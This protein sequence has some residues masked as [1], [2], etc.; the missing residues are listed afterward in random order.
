MKFRFIPL[1]TVFCCAQLSCRA[2]EKP[3]EHN[4][5]KDLPSREIIAKLPADGGDEFNR[6][7][8]ETSPYLRQHARNPVDWYPWGPEAFARAKKENKPIFLS[9]GYSSC[10]WCHVMEHESFEV[11]EVADVLN[12]KFICIKVDREERPDV[13]QIYMNATQLLTGR[14]GWP[15]SVFMDADQRPFFCGTYFRKPDFIGIL[16]NIDAV[17]KKD[18]ARIDTTADQIA[19]RLQQMAYQQL[20]AASTPPTRDAITASIQSLQSTF[21]SRRGGFGGAPKFPPHQ[22]LALLLYAYTQTKDAAVLQM[23]NV[24]LMEMAKG[25]IHDHVGGGFHRYSTDADWFLPHFEKMLYDNA[26]LSRVYAEAYKVTGNEWYE[27]VARGINDW[28]LRDM[29]DPAG[30]FW[31]AYDADSEGEE[32]KYYLWGRKEL[33]EILGE[34]AAKAL[35]EAYNAP[36]GG[37][38]HEEATGESKPVSILH[39]KQPWSALTNREALDT[40]LKQLRAVRNKRVWPGLDDKVLTAWNGLMIGGLAYGGKHLKEPRYIAAAEKAADF[41]L[42][43]MRKPDGRLYTTYRDGQAKL[44]AYLDDYAFLADGLIDLYEATGEKRWLNE[45]DK[46]LQV[47]MQDFYDETYGGFYFTA[48][49]HE[50][51]LT[52]NK[53]PFDA[54]IPSG[55]GIATK[56]LIRLAK[57]LDKPA[58]AVTGR[59]TIDTFAGMIAQSPRGTMS[60][61]QAMA[62]YYDYGFAEEKAPAPAVATGSEPDATKAETP[63]KAEAFLSSL[64]VAPGGE[65]QVALR[66]SLDPHWHVNA[67]PASS[68]DLIPTI[69]AID[70]GENLAGTKVAYPAGVDF[71]SAPDVIQV[72]EGSVLLRTT[73]KA[74]ASAREGAREIALTVHYQSCDDKGVC[75]LPAKLVLKIPVSIAKDAV[76]GKRHPGIFK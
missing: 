56:V 76:P 19:E 74:A 40:S 75:L 1:L 47:L 55:N 10:H 14:G 72:Y 43:A 35:A 12:E 11:D 30:G 34:T 64:R 8:H 37:N 69:L 39:L 73:L 18:R 62:L 7:I 27:Q 48:E 9:I 66:L 15:N 71:G 36:V 50:N 28:V 24:T 16:N 29:Q 22:S 53:D 41:M 68:P 46:L 51:L 63:L 54:A 20:P 49:G 57:H 23:V 38:Y 59:H 21:D 25:G 70:A 31:S 61:L 32:G 6:L 26:Q 4:V 45:A 42:R 58:Y 2:A 44:D 65:L 5:R 3:E 67:N 13:D 60:F 17:W 33:T 52:R